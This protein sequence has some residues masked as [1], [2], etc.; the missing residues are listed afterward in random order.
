MIFDFIIIIG[1]INFNDLGKSKQEAANLRPKVCKPKITEI[2][3]QKQEEITNDR[4]LPKEFLQKL[5]KNTEIINK[6]KNKNN[7]N[8]T[9]KVGTTT[10]IST[11]TKNMENFSFIDN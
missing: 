5:A 1:I 3:K 7:I 8:N 2:L 11:G 4:R 6:T 10:N 9:G